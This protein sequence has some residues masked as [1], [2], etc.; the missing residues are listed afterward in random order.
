MT[1][2]RLRVGTR[3]SA[4]AIAQ[5]Q[6]VVDC[7]RQR[8][9][10]VHLDMVT[11]VTS[12]DKKMDLGISGWSG[13]GVFVKE[14]EDALLQKKIDLAIHSLK[15]LPTEIPKGLTIAAYSKREEDRDV[16]VLSQRDAR[17]HSGADALD[18]I[19]LAGKV[20]TSSL[21]RAAQINWRRPDVSVIPIRG[22]L[23]TRLRKLREEGL[24]A[25]VVA[26]AGLN[27]LGIQSPTAYLLPY[28]VS[29]PAVGQG[30]LA[31]EVRKEDREALE[32]AKLV[33]DP[34]TA[35]EVEAER[36]FLIAMEGGC[37]IPLAARAQA[38]GQMIRL[39]GMVASTKRFRQIHGAR[40]GSAS[41]AKKLGHELARQFVRA[42]ARK[43]LEE[44]RA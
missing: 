16:I 26:A 18:G 25:I 37:R 7:L 44:S 33:H 4:L 28:K 12:G 20:G 19:P 36:A 6:W 34:Q 31:V 38:K 41:R 32:I 43:F 30:V 3:G 17:Y 22:N 24:D 14:I 39:Q 21:R 8:R 29:L 35:H 40:W 5:T 42:G 15:D 11:I 10:D 13:K 2:R 9:P 27:R 1:G 23:E